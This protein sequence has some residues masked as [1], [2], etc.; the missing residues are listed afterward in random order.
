MRGY[1]LNNKYESLRMRALFVGL[2]SNK[3]GG[4]LFNMSFWFGR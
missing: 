1:R 3:K 4:E 2:N